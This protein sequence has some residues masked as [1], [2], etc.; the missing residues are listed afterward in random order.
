MIKY[1]FDNSWVFSFEMH[2]VGISYIFHSFS[3][4]ELI[5]FL[6]LIRL[7]CIKFEFKCIKGCRFSIPY[8]I[9]FYLRVNTVSICNII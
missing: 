7:K 8:K 2:I 4:A 3:S 1:K 5:I 9:L 6:E